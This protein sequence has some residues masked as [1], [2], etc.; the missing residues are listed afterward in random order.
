MRNNKVSSLFVLAAAIALTSGVVACQKNATQDTSTQSQPAQADQSQDPAA[1]AN[2]APADATQATG[3][4]D[5][6]QPANQ[7]QL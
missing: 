5:Q 1:A 2:L 4:N 6:Q 3:T 7:A